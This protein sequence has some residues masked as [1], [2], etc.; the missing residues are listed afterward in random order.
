MTDPILNGATIAFDLDGTLID[1]APDLIGALNLVL[2]EQGL[3]RVPMSSATRLIGAGPTGLV[4]R[5]FAE[6]GHPLDADRAAV[7]VERLVEVYLDRISEESAPFPGM[8]EALDA[9]AAAGAILC[10]CTNKREGLSRSLLEALGQTH[11]FAA[12]L[13]SDSAP[14]H[15]PDAGHLI[16]TVRAAG[17]DMARTLYVGD[18][19]TDLLTARAAGVPSIGVSFGYS[20][21]AA[22]D[23]GFDRLIDSYAELPAVAAELLRAL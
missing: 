2:A 8:D 9:L 19:E 12:I 13:G 22:A 16:A 11:R 10:V 5:G 21:T 4:E 14:V 7:L 17:G 6:L 18:S 23:L 3:G 1:T 15:K 20:E